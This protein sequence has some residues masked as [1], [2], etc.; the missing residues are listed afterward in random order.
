MYRSSPRPTTLKM[1]EMTV[2]ICTPVTATL[3]FGDTL[4]HQ[5]SASDD[6]APEI[7]RFADTQVESEDY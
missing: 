3:D 5:S 6:S 7:R 1:P 4:Q 2:E